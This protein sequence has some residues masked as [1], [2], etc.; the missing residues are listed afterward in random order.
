MIGTLGRRDSKPSTLSPETEKPSTLSPESL[1]QRPSAYVAPALLSSLFSSTP[2]CPVSPCNL[3]A[4]AFTH[5]ANN[6]FYYSLLAW[7]PSYFAGALHLQVCVRGPW[8]MDSR[9]LRDAF[10]HMGVLYACIYCCL[11]LWQQPWLQLRYTAFSHCGCS[12]AATAF[13]YCWKP[14][15]PIL[16]SSPPCAIL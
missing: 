9:H 16:I 4:L 8:I 3:Q 5:F 10:V 13:S 14:G 6:W 1:C 12:H 7:M 15:P 2:R 11:R